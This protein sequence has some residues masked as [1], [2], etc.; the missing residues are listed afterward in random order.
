MSE[1]VELMISTGLSVIAFLGVAYVHNGTRIAILELERK[2]SETYVKQ[3]AFRHEMSSLNNGMRD[4]I[5]RLE[6]L[7]RLWDR[8][9]SSVVPSGLCGHPECPLENP[10]HPAFG[11]DP[12]R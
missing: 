7:Q 11:D 1:Y 12:P 8:R 3:E 9:I 2:V 6:S 4:I 5:G 10:A